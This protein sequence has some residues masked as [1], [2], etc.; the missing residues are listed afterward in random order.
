MATTREERVENALQ[1]LL[2]RLVP[3]D[4]DEDEALADQRWD[5]ANE[6][7]RH[8]LTAEQEPSVE[9]D[10]NHAADLITRR[11]VRESGTPERAAVFR[12]LYSRLLAQPVLGQKWAILYFLNQLADGGSTGSGRNS[13]A[14]GSR[15][16]QRQNDGAQSFPGRAP[17]ENDGE[18]V[19]EG[20]QQRSFEP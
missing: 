3:Q 17:E 11:L 9:E 6:I 8:H 5:E 19:E 13:S 15:A 18:E 2:E 7:A 12:N 14:A 1:Q 20:I 4:P 10:V 16:Q